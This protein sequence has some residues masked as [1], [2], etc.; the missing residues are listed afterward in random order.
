MRVCGLLILLILTGCSYKPTPVVVFGHA[1]A[2]Y[3]A[4]TLCEALIKCK[5]ASEDSCYYNS[6]VS[7]D[8]TGNKELES[9]KEIKLPS[10]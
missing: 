9:C 8:Y 7:V 5:Q 10:K 6:T 3:S 4:P 1:G 2:Q